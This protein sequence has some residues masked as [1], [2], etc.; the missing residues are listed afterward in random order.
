MLTEADAQENLKA[1]EGNSI[2]S[3]HH[4]LSGSFCN[5]DE[6]VFDW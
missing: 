4:L 1:T 6:L 5:T 2:Q 3:K